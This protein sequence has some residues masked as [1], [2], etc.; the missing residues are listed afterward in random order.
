MESEWFKKE[1]DSL[2]T[3]PVSNDQSPKSPTLNEPSP[4]KTFEPSSYISP[5]KDQRTF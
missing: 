2:A 5:R 1:F 4:L 3:S